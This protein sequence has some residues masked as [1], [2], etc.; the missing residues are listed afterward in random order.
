MRTLLAV[1]VGLLASALASSAAPQAG[2]APS[3]L[4]FSSTFSGDREIFTASD[5]GSNRVDLTRDPHADITPSWSADG[6]RIA[7]ASNRS[8]AFE[9]YVMNADGSNVVQVTHDNAY[10]DDPRFTGYDKAIVYESNKGGSWEIRRIGVDGSGEV[11]LTRNRAADRYPATSSRGA[12]AFASDRGGAGEHIW[13]MRWNGTRP[14]QLTLQ[15]GGQSQPAWDPSG[16]RL[17]FVAGSPAQGTAVWSVLANGKGLRRL[18]PPNDRNELSPSWSPDGSSIV[19]QDCPAGTVTSCDL[20]TMPIGSAP[21]D[22]ST[23]R[24]PFV[25]T[26]D[27]G[28]G[29]F[30]QVIQ[31]GSGAVNAEENGQLVTTL[32]ADSVQGGQYDQIETHW[33]TQC[34]LVGDFDVQVDYRLLEWPAANGVQA[35]L[36]SFAG[37]SNIAFMAIRESQVWGEQYGSWIPQDFSSVPTADSAGTLRLQREGDTAVT[38]DWNGVDWIPLASGPTSTDSA[39]I[40]LGA[41]SFMNRFAH[42]EVK[43]AWDNFRINSGTISC[44][45]PWWEDDSPGWH[46]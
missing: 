9:I 19:Y 6:R 12:I 3:R 7:F 11:D 10:A 42:Q 13:V 22:A 2:A 25:D 14:R 35:A 26:F 36:S 17:A 18:T 21:V 38:S 4:V 16:T 40:A 27:G 5:D 46:T 30:W 44:G 32:A 1:A 8:G 24:A 41:S 20:M 39:T 43:V 45:T 34:R 28:D 29:R 33:G 31:F 15:R 37:P 23:L